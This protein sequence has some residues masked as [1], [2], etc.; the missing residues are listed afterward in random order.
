LQVAGFPVLLGGRAASS[1]IGPVG[2]VLVIRDATAMGYPVV[3]MEAKAPSDQI[4]KESRLG[5]WRR[6]TV[7][8]LV[9][10][11]LF[12]LLFY[13]G[14]YFA[15]ALGGSLWYPAAGLRGATL[16][17]FGWRLTPGLA[18]AELL[19]VG[20]YG[21]L[22]PATLYNQPFEVLLVASSPILYGA[23]AW[24]LARTTSFDPRLRHL[25]DM[26]WFT[27]FAV[28]A[29]AANAVESR[30]VRI[31]LG[32]LAPE[33]F[34]S[35]AFGFFIGDTIGVLMLTPILLTAWRRY[36]PAS[37]AAPPWTSKPSA[38]KPAAFVARLL[39]DVLL[40]WA[41]LL[42]L[43]QLPSLFSNL[44][45][46]IHW[47]LAFLPMIWISF[48]HGLPGSIAGAAALTSGAAWL[49]YLPVES[50][51]F[52]ELQILVAFLSV[53]S[54]L[55]GSAISTHWR[56]E[57]KLAGQNR[58]LRTVRAQLEA[59]NA[60]LARFNYTVA[61]D[62][63]N[64]L[65]TIKNFLG[66]LRQ[67]AARGDVDR[68]QH[69]LDRVENAAAWMQLLVWELS[70]LS[71]I[72]SRTD[73]P[74]M[75]PLAEVVREAVDGLA[76]TISEHHI[77][78]EVAMDLPQVLGDREL[79]L[80]LVH[81]LLENAVQYL[82][83]QP[84]PRI[85]VGSRRNGKPVGA[86][87]G[88]VIFVRDNGIGVAPEYHDKIF[89]LFERLAPEAS[90]GTGIGLTLVKRIVEVHGGRIWVES[91]GRGLGSTFCFTLSPITADE[92]DLR[93]EASGTIERPA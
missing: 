37:F 27:A 82:G 56:T 22:R 2:E 85:E 5:R 8:T 62:L 13:L 4:G 38:E 52:Q 31:L 83:D 29:P 71:K 23:A 7:V 49:F 26:A 45:S 81:H 55:M 79:L 32:Q 75:V 39:P 35:S 65:V 58:V 86:G 40:V 1:G 6:S 30:V 61:H 24:L 53:T 16:L 28:A 78:V 33:D 46:H 42:V 69:D 93:N 74:M 87:D 12:F 91:E 80:R 20:L 47:Y 25:R 3:T 77:G 54:L 76:E 66:L 72:S 15:V 36:R 10:G 60:D 48:R 50:I 59:K 63:R 68:I 64:P 90:E 41:F 57:Q 43:H 67:D 34:V 14:S 51:H 11:V 73:G 21:L 44:T 84:S 19:A 18:V 92:D 88:P 70:E 17:I 89:G 9:Y